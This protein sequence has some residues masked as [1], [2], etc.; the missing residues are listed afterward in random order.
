MW[1]KQME[2]LPRYEQVLALGRRLVF[3]LGTE[4]S[5]RTLCGWMAHYI[6]ELI[7]AADNASSQ[8]G[9]ALKEKCYD[10]ILKLWKHRAA[11][12][13][14]MDPLEDFKP[15]ARAL[16]RLDPDSELSLFRYAS[17]SDPGLDE[18][19]DIARLLEFARLVESTARILIYYTFVDAARIATDKSLTWLDIASDIDHLAPPVEMIVQ[20]GV[21]E[22]SNDERK[23]NACERER[24]E[25]EE[26]I[27][28]LDE[29]V[30]MASEFRVKLSA[31]L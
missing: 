7:D 28:R 12:P 13:N 14:G 2:A 10:S 17:D 26:Y 31:R 23:K 6:A 27:Q 1:S 30:T 3:E 9:A 22:S 4:P 19:P 16:K 21:A 24:K 15:I 25:I 11:L 8:E 5:T 20:F 29:F 18:D